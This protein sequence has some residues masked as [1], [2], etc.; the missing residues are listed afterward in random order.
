MKNL[1][2]ADRQH[3]TFE[4]TRDGFG[5]GLA[6]LGKSNPAVVAL[7]ADLTESTRVQWFAKSFPERFIQTGVAEEN[8][9]GLA[10]G[11]ALAGKIPFA[12]SYA[13]FSP[14]NS[15]GPIRSSICY[16]NLPVTIVGGHA[17]LG[18]G[19]D[20][21]THQS[22][23]DI[24]L[25]RVLPNMTVVVPCDKEEARKATHAV[26]ALGSPAY[27]RTGRAA[28]LT[29]TTA[30][31]PFK[32]G[33]GIELCE[34]SDAVIIACGPLVG[35]ALEAAD[36]LEKENIHIGVVNM[37]TI[38]PLD[39]ELIQKLCTT[40]PAIFTLEDHQV[41][42]GLGSAVAEVLAQESAHPPLTML[43]VHDRFGQS[44]K[45]EELYEHYGLSTKQIMSSIREVV[46]KTRNTSHK[47]G[48]A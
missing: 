5:I 30:K 45:P 18:T 48:A 22:L 47:K 3:P 33:K 34:G 16:S 46:T 32:L 14:A 8:M 44:G 39:T 24:A 15:W 25:M 42:G 9:I 12:S 1:H 40:T 38:K 29:V 6:E 23:E 11:L 13:C 41:I 37:H 21:A 27:L 35:N 4:T 20:G 2:L 26:A 17:G 28:S 43:G 7:C 19:P 31:T 36:R 10:A